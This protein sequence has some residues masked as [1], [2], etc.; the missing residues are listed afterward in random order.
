MLE[1]LSLPFNTFTSSPPK[2]SMRAITTFASGLLLSAL[3]LLAPAICAAE[4]QPFATLKI[5]GINTL[6]SVAEKYA[7]MAGVDAPEFPEFIN[8]VKNIKGVDLDGI[9]G[10]AAAVDDAGTINMILLLPITDLWRAEVPGMPEIFD[11][12]RPFLVRKG[13]GRIEINAPMG[14]YIAVQRLG[15]LVITPEDVAEQV[16]TD[17]RKYFADLEKYTIGVKLDLEKVDFETI[18]SQLFGPMLLMAMMTNPAAAQQ[19]EPMVE[20]YR[21]L[22][23]E[24]AA[25][26]YGIAANP[27]TADV[28]LS[29]SIIP[30]KGSEIAKSFAG[31]KQQPTIFDGFRGTPATTVFSIGDSATQPQLE[32]NAM[33]KLSAKQWEAM[34]EGFLEQIEMEDETGE[35]TELAKAAVESIT[36]IIETEAKRGASDAALSLNT[37]GTLLFAFDTVSLAEIQKLVTLAQA[38]VNKNAHAEAKKLLEDGANLAYATVEGFKISSVKIPVVATLEQFVG[39]APDDAAPLRDLTLNLYWAVKEGDK[40]AIA[41]AVGLDATKTEQTFKAALT[42]TK[43]A[44]PAQKPMGSFSISGLGKFLQQSVYP[45]AERIANANGDIDPEMFKKVNEIFASAGND[46]TITFDSEVKSDR[47]DITY[48]VSG[49]VIQAIISAV[50]SG[51]E[52]QS[53]RYFPKN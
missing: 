45:I 49:K 4:L 46:A 23:K 48:R 31:H 39:P 13:E 34:L 33:V 29:M 51:F 41:V 11:Q 5:S 36:K 10:I 26:S 6:I 8:T 16:P 47:M 52:A 17:P 30:R 1:L 21:E 28:E 20:L 53:T 44:A 19:L 3:L 14:T 38:F 32:N 50:R 25:L 43:T 9:I 22:Y 18:E 7:G 24:V 37:D 2:A 42:Q 12:I 27:R 15:Y 40:Q 35:R